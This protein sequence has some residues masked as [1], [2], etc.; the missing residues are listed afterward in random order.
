V[1]ADAAMSP[2]DVGWSLITTRSVFDH[3]AVVVGENRDELMA[4]LKALAAGE[5]HPGV[6]EPG[7]AAAVGGLGGGGVGPVLVFPG[8]GSQWAGMGAGLLDTSP[9]FAA[10]VADCEQALAPYVDWS[11]TDVL[12]DGVHTADLSRVDVVQ[13]VLWAVMISLA[14]LWDDY[15]VTPAAVVGHSQG[16]IAAACVAGALSLQEGARIVALRSQALRHLTGGGAMAS[17]GI[18]Q[19]QAEEILAACG[20][21]A[22]AVGVAAVNGPGSVVVSGP[23]EQVDHAVAAC[24]EAGGRARLIDVDYASHSPQVDEIAAELTEV[25]AGV[26]PVPSGV[27]FY[28]T[29]T[30]GRMDTAGLDTAYWVTNLRER[31]RFADAVRALLADGHRVFIETSTHPVLTIGLQESFEEAGVNAVTVPTLRRDHGG[32][33]QLTRSVAQAFTAG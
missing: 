27:A 6:I 30:A 31:V 3:R 21:R 23:P 5:P 29:V 32:P 17:L 20:E 1:A 25:L 11:L 2:A 15:G 33:A 18:S 10:R 13:P 8:Q 26:K 16:E 28:S 4:G 24:E 7:S 22:E 12:R 19:D 9:V 14:A